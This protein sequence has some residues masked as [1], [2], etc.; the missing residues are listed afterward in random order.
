MHNDPSAGQLHLGVLALTSSIVTA[1]LDPAAHQKIGISRA[2]ARAMVG[3][4]KGGHDNAG[5]TAI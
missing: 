2:N 1:G 3:R 4:L 5:V